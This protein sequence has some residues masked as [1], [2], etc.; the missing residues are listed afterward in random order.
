MWWCLVT[1]G[2]HYAEVLVGGGRRV[3]GGGALSPRAGR[4]WEES[5]SN[6]GRR[7]AETRRGHVVLNIRIVKFCFNVSSASKQT[8]RGQREEKKQ[9]NTN[10]N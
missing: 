2:L 1:Q 10:L 4:H 3:G 9:F 7:A 8:P 5:S 6:T